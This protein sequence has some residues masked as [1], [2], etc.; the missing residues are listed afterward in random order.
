VHWL[1]QQLTASDSS[2]TIYDKLSGLLCFLN[3]PGTVLSW[4]PVAS[5]SLKLSRSLDFYYQAATTAAVDVMLSHHP[6]SAGYISKQCAEMFLITTTGKVTSPLQVWVL[7]L[8]LDPD[9]IGR[10]DLPSSEI[11]EIPWDPNGGYY[12]WSTTK[13]YALPADGSASARATTNLQRL[14]ADVLET[15][16]GRKH[17]AFGEHLQ[18][19]MLRAAGSKL[20]FCT[21]VAEM[22]Q[23][24]KRARGKRGAG[25]TGNCVL[26]VW[27]VKW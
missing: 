20:A 14:A 17:V 5:I 26:D 3:L 1:E 4:L 10:P 6:L 15:C 16:V 23:P 8:D 19:A 25:H 27:V 12:E 9:W 11:T 18:K 2:S 21:A 7:N 24:P 22:S 13:A